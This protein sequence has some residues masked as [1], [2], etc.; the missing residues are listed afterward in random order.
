MLVLSKYEVNRKYS[1]FVGIELVENADDGIKIIA[2]NNEWVGLIQTVTSYK[3]N[4]KCP[5][6][7]GK[8]RDEELVITLTKMHTFFLGKFIK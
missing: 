5:I 8:V 4:R 1:F 2:N 3:F 6:A 7:V